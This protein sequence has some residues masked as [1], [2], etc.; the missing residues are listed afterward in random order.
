M[1]DYIVVWECNKFSYH[2]KLGNEFRKINESKF[3]GCYHLADLFNRINDFLKIFE[4]GFFP[5]GISIR[6]I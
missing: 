3:D 2:S 6:E 4:N 5:E 1:K